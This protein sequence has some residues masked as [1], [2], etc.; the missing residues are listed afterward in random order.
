MAANKPGPREIKGTPVSHNLSDIVEDILNYNSDLPYEVIYIPVHPTK[1][2]YKIT[3]VDIQSVPKNRGYI[4]TCLLQARIEQVRP[5]DASN[6][7]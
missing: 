7:A 5:R 2:V 4:N 6:S 3:Y 1:Y